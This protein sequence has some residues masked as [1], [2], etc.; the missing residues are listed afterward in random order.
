VE[1][2]DLNLQIA[3]ATLALTGTLVDNVI[4]R[5]QSDQWFKRP[6]PTSTHVLWIVGHLATTRALLAKVLGGGVEQ[7]DP[8]FAGGCPL[9]A[10]DAF[11]PPATV[12]ARWRE[13]RAR[14][15]Q[16]VL[17]VSPSDL[18]RPSPQG[19]PTLNGRVSGL[20]AAFV[21]HEA[22]HIGQLGYLMRWLGHPP[23]LG[24]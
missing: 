12:A 4:E 9:P 2:E 8:L 14:V 24:R 18:D 10:E 11:P 3:I 17:T 5:I 20:L 21:F 6:A 1:A 19:I 23:L 15:D 7:M 13:A 22:Y 16:V